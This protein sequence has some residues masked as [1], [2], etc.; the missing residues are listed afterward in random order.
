MVGLVS[1]VGSHVVAIYADKTSAIR[2]FGYNQ[3]VMSSG[4]VSN[5]I[6]LI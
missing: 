4:M 3:P 1:I 5:M 6:C 2:V